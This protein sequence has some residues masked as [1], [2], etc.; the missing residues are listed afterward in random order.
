MIGNIAL[1]LSNSDISSTN[2]MNLGHY[3]YLTNGRQGDCFGNLCEHH[4][5][6]FHIS[7]WCKWHATALKC[8]IVVMIFL[9]LE[10]I[11]VVML[12]FNWFF[13]WS[14]HQTK[15]DNYPL[16]KSALLYS[17]SLHILL[18]GHVIP[19]KTPCHIQLYCP[20]QVN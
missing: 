1:F 10:E 15:T 13:F 3:F 18:C 20:N 8:E 12:T 19:L 2:D 11:P 16:I 4:S 9:V 7:L 17:T 6:T 5:L 14:R